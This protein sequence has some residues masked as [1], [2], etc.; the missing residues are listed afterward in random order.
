LWTNSQ[1]FGNPW[2]ESFNKAIRTFDKLED[3]LRGALLLK[4][5]PYRPPP[6]IHCVERSTGRQW[7]LC[8]WLIVGNSWPIDADDVSACVRKCHCRKRRRANSG[9]FNNL[10]ALEWSGQF[11]FSL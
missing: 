6:T 4:V 8:N 11:L 2:T 7:T 1:T 3:D 9:D 10:Y 5:K